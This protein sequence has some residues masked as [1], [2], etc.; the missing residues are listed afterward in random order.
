M[1]NSIGYIEATQTYAASVMN[2]NAIDNGTRGV[3]NGQQRQ[4]ELNELLKEKKAELDKYK[5][6]ADEI[7][8]KSGFEKTMGGLFGNDCGAADVQAKTQQAMADMR[9]AAD[10]IKICEAQID[11]MMQEIQQAQQ[12]MSDAASD[13]QK[14][15]DESNRATAEAASV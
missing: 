8:N 6:E 12:N 3:Q 14:S 11:A 5:A 2:G 1:G 10:Q 7:K 15:K 4:K 9:K 13:N